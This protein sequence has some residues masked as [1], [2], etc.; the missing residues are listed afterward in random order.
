[1]NGTGGFKEQWCLGMQQ[2]LPNK[3][4]TAGDAWTRLPAHVSS[5]KPPELAGALCSVLASFG[6]RFSE[7][8]E[9]EHDGGHDE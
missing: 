5:I 4:R 3:K 8:T 1:M 6:G 9:H 2:E 7:T